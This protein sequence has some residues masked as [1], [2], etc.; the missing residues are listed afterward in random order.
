MRIF[1]INSKEDVFKIRDVN[2]CISKGGDIFVMIYMEGCSPCNATRPEWAKIESALKDQYKKNDK[3]V[4]VDI[5]HI[6]ASKLNNIGTVAGFPTMKYITNYGKTV[7][8]YEDSSVQK[9]DRTITSF[10]NWIETKINT[11]VSTTPS[12]S[13]NDVYN[14]IVK[15]KNYNSRTKSRTK[16]R[17]PKSRRPKSI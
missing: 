3:L 2:K 11:T 4:I 10:I 1:H 12:S 9:K 15:M 16:S 13:T 7:E 5:N 17:R 8:S 14:R 6:Y